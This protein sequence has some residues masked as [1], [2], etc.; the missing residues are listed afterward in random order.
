M[1]EITDKV[2]NLTYYFTL[3]KVLETVKHENVIIWQK[4]CGKN[5]YIPNCVYKELSNY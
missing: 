1:I 2:H 4:G 5:S 3:E